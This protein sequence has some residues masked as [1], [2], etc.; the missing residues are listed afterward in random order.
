MIAVLGIMAGIIFGLYSVYFIRIIKGNPQ[1]FEI[2][3]LRALA[4]WIV[5]TGKASKIQLWMM[6]IV[7]L[8]MEG[9]YFFLTFTLIKNLF[10]LG[11]TASFAGMETYHLITVAINLKRFFAGKSSITN[12]LNWRIERISAVL[13]FTHSLLVLIILLFF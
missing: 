4:A 8:L 3:L 5:N 13:F 10:M 2:E 11:L 6:Y 7:S 9:I 12:I 1:T